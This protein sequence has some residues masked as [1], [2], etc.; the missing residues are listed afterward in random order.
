MV[1]RDD[2]KLWDGSVGEGHVLTV[3]SDGFFGDARTVGNTFRHFSMMTPPHEP[4]TLV[5][6]IFT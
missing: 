2:V 3:R 5:S 6:F 4:E 1:K